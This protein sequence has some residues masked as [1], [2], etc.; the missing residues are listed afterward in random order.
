MELKWWQDPCF[1]GSVKGY[2]FSIWKDLFK[3]SCNQEKEEPSYVMSFL[4]CPC[5]CIGLSV[6]LPCVACKEY[7]IYHTIRNTND[8]LIV[9]QPTSYNTSINQSIENI[10]EPVYSKQTQPIPIKQTQPIPIKQNGYYCKPRY[11]II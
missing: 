3:I 11:T 10:N 7:Q 9:E 6:F 4:C 8:I 5:S 2:T 1:C